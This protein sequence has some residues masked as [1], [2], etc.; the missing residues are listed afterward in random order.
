MDIKTRLRQIF[1]PHTIIVALLFNLA[2][3]LLLYAFLAEDV[4][5]GVDYLSYFISAYTLVI[6]CLRMPDLPL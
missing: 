3:V 2:V 5:V 4:I 6:V 1:Y